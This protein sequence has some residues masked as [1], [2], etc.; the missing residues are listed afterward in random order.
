MCFRNVFFA[1]VFLC[2]SQII[3]AQ[4]S[5]ATLTGIV[6]DAN[7]SVV[8]GVKISVVNLDTKLT[9]TA[10][11]N[12]EGNFRFAYLPIGNYEI[13]AEQK[14]FETFGQKLSVSVGQVLDLKIT[15]IV[16]NVSS[17]R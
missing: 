5:S 9:Q 11:S 8:G 16:Q 14:G 4:V 10:I 2:F 17:K 7:K 1:A 15:L 12:A 3:N 6:S 13:K